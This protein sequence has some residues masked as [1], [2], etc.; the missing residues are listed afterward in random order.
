MNKSILKSL[1][2]C[3]WI[4]CFLSHANCADLGKAA[5]VMNGIL[6]VWDGATNTRRVL[7]SG[8]DGDNRPQWSADGKTIL[9]WSAS[10]GAAGVKD[11]EIKI[12][13]ATS[14]AILNGWRV[15]FSSD[16]GVRLAGVRE[17]KQVGWYGTGSIFIL[18]NVSPIA[19]E[20]RIFDIYKHEEQLGFVGYGFSVC[21][22]APISY[23]YQPAEGKR[24]YILTKDGI[25][26]RDQPSKPIRL[27]APNQ[28]CNTWFGVKI[29]ASQAELVRIGDKNNEKVALLPF[30]D[31]LR[32]ELWVD[33]M[34]LFRPTGDID[35]VDLNP[36]RRK[37]ARKMASEI[38]SQRLERIRDFGPAYD[39]FR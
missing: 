19:D 34:I 28:D 20:L 30:A 11:V 9:Y 10:Q 13:S 21:R 26:L 18:G 17:V 3:F 8:L 38:I 15:D 14:G 22:S 32:M 12:L 33:N 36:L 35:I 31:Y 39:W 24:E 25:P 4:G 16:E 27:I 37:D 7:M 23:F 29:D 1:G 5:Y 6:V 2:F